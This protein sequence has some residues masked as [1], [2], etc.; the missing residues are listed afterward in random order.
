M[1]IKRTANDVVYVYIEFSAPFIVSP[2]R[3]SLPPLRFSSLLSPPRWDFEG[4]L[5]SEPP[6]FLDH[7]GSLRRLSP[8]FAQHRTIIIIKSI[9]LWDSLTVARFIAIKSHCITQVS[10]NNTI[11]CSEEI[12][13]KKAI[14]AILST[15]APR[16]R[17]IAVLALKLNK[18]K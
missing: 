8:S 15:V 5:Y 6:C 12:N 14:A 10:H 11:D 3:R 17:R 4:V 16:R 2:R 18:Y 9:H 13:R 1:L 7:D